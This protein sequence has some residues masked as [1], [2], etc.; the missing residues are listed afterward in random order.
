[1]V[2][3]PF[4]PRPFRNGAGGTSPVVRWLRSHAPNAG[5]SRFDP[6]SGKEIPHATNETQHSQIHISFNK[7][8]ATIKKKKKQK[9]QQCPGVALHHENS[10][11]AERHTRGVKSRPSGI[12]FC[13]PS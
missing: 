11:G 8:E 2:S 12:K 6:W 4:R 1:M 3:P 7:F 5:G 13:G 9:K 10:S